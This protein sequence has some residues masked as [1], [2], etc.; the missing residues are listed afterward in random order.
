M[1]VHKLAKTVPKKNKNKSKF[2]KIKIQHFTLKLFNST[3]K[4]SI[5][6]Y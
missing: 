3:S 6:Q 4:M 5:R 1:L 2:P